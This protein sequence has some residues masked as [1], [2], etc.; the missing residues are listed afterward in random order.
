MMRLMDRI[1]AI[2]RS[3]RV[4]ALGWIALLPLLGL[5]PAICALVSVGQIRARYQDSWNP[6]SRYLKAGSVMAR[7]GFYASATI[8]FLVIAAFVL[9]LVV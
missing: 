7:I 3:M 8:I 4:F 5:I 2:R 6:A 1:E 9:G